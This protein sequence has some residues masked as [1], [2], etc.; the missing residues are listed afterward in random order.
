MTSLPVSF[1]SLTN[2]P[3][4]LFSLSNGSDIPNSRLQLKVNS[5]RSIASDSCHLVA[6]K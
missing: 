6:R 3:L 5:I 1:S 2:S 4:T